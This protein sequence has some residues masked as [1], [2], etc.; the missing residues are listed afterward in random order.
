MCLNMYDVRKY[1]TFPACGMNWPEDL[2]EATKYL[3]VRPSVSMLLA[4]N[5]HILC[6]GT[7]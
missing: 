2:G 4:F 5:T 7:T 3:D 1:D 6:R